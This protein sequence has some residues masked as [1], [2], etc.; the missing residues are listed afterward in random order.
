[1]THRPSIDSDEQQGPGRNRSLP[2]AD[3]PF[4]EPDLQ[5][6]LVCTTRSGAREEVG[7]GGDG[8]VNWLSELGAEVGIKVV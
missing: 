4:I 8:Q 3:D 7:D 1:M 6:L 5:S 2:L